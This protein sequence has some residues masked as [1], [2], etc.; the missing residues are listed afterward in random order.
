MPKGVNTVPRQPQDRPAEAPRNPLPD[1]SRMWVAMERDLRAM[2]KFAEAREWSSLDELNAALWQSMEGRQPPE[3][4][5]DSPLE[6]AQ[7]LAWRAWEADTPE[8]RIRLAREAL[9]ISADC[10]DAYVILGEEAGDLKQAIGWFEQG[11]AAGERALGPERFAED[12][13]HFWRMVD[14]RPYMR[15]RWRLAVALWEAESHDDAI[16]H[17]QALIELNPSDNQGVRYLLVNWLLAEG[18]TD[19][20]GRLLDRY[21][22][23][24][25]AF[26]T[27][28]RALWRFQREGDTAAARRDLGRAIKGN[29][30]VVRFIAELVEGGS[31]PEPP[32]TYGFGDESEALAYLYDGGLE[33]WART[34][35]ALAWMGRVIIE[36][37][38]QLEGRTRRR[39][40]VGRNDPCP[41]GSGR[42]YKHCCMPR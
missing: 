29:P 36:N 3:F 18:R 25:S 2:Q 9:A 37:L 8:E 19:D 4:V 5:A 33:S 40:K 31:L 24:D 14:T 1:P 7:E 13:G 39:V 26:F 21:V 12:A 32:A 42:K 16:A 17:A 15:A 10:A 23:D 22:D 34:D 41:C 6:R 11:V 30:Y 20:A 27:H 28:A 38:G 35:G